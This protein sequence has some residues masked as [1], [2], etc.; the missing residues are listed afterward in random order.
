MLSERSSG[1][2]QWMRSTRPID[3][4][5]RQVLLMDSPQSHRKRTA[6]LAEVVFIILL[7]LWTAGLVTGHS[8]AGFLH[9][10][11]VVALLVLVIFQLHPFR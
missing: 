5:S 1:Q 6:L 8:F 9:V 2:W 11:L 3:S 7:I 10:L 4:T